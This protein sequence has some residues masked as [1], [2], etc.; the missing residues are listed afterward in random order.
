[1]WATNEDVNSYDLRFYSSENETKPP[2]LMI[3]W[4]NQPKTVY[5]L[6]DHLGSVRATVLGSAGAP[7]VAFD[8]Y[9]P[10]GYIL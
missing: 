9:D 10:W 4:S 2:E 6:K 8:D 5:F 3:I 1:M 7:V